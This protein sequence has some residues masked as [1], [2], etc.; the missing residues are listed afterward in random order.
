MRT[1]PFGFTLEAAP[2][3]AQADH[4]SGGPVVLL[5][6]LMPGLMIAFLFATDAVEDY[7]F[8]RLPAAGDVS[9]SADDIQ[10]HFP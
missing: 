9:P 7:L 6:L 8:P 1:T 5:A 4:P 2:S 3:A 10:P